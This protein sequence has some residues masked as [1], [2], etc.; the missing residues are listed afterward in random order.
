MIGIGFARFL[1]FVFCPVFRP[2]YGLYIIF[3]M[4]SIFLSPC[5]L[6][7]VFQSILE[8]ISTLKANFFTIAKV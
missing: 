2:N 5:K 3:N 7:V 6:L 1:S 4:P 8:E